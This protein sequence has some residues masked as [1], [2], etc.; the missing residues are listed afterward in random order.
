MNQF[1]DYELI[2]FYMPGRTLFK[3]KVHGDTHAWANLVKIPPYA[4][5][6]LSPVPLIP[7]NIPLPPLSPLSHTEATRCHMTW[8]QGSPKTSLKNAF[9]SMS[10]TK[11][12]IVICRW[13][14]LN[15][16]GRSGE[17][18]SRLQNNPQRHASHLYP[19][20][21][22]TLDTQTQSNTTKH[23]KNTIK[24]NPKHNPM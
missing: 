4:Y 2:N 21:Q 11:C 18:T 22:H 8:F 15:V 24:H 10:C 5:P 7:L 12:Q 1:V 14:L 23:K 16:E 3:H 13:L 6:P 9:T 20:Q 19:M 17:C